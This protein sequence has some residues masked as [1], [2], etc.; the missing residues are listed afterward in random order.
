MTSWKPSNI[1][2]SI[3]LSIINLRGNWSSSFQCI[4]VLKLIF[5]LLNML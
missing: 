1:Q 2:L 5:Y 4:M 3:Q